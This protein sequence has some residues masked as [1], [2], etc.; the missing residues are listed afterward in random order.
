VVGSTPVF[1]PVMCRVAGFD[2]RY[3]SGLFGFTFW[4]KKAVHW[5]LI[6]QGRWCGAAERPV[7]MLAEHWS[8]K[9]LPR[10]APVEF[11]LVGGRGRRIIWAQELG[12]SQS[13]IAK[14]TRE[15]SPTWL[16]GRNLFETGSHYVAQAGLDLLILL[17]QPPQCRDYTLYVNWVFIDWEKGDE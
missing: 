9:I 3:I 11:R 2:L 15:T 1:L 4:W 6:D 13:N 5:A 8:T 7:G 17:P 12:T 16:T 10:A 14:P